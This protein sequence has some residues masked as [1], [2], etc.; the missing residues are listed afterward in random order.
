MT[1]GHQLVSVSAMTII[2]IMY[3]T[4]VG[5]FTG[6]QIARSVFLINPNS[7]SLC[8]T[9]IQG[10]TESG[11]SFSSKMSNSILPSISLK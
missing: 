8:I 10:L 2:Y 3:V 6:Y 11:C 1:F 5:L 9:Q 4:C 7:C